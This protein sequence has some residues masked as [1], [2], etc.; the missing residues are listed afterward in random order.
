ML[1]TLSRSM[2]LSFPQCCC[3]SPFQNFN[4]KQNCS[5]AHL[6]KVHVPLNADAHAADCIIMVLVAASEGRYQGWESEHSGCLA[7]MLTAVHSCC[8]RNAG[9]AQG[10][11]S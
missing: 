2:S 8:K 3:S 10:Q 9:G 4:Q 1:R 11:D 6:V 5:V 7:V